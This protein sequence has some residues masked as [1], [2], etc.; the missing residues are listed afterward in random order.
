MTRYLIDSGTS[1]FDAF[2]ANPTD[3]AKNPTLQK[4]ETF[5]APIWNGK[6]ILT[7]HGTAGQPAK[8]GLGVTYWRV[9]Q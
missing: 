4:V 9:T 3:P 7:P 2:V 8:L 1:N 6:L 5:T